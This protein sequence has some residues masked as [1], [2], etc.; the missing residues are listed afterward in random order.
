V[1]AAKADMIRPEPRSHTEDVTQTVAP[2]Y[3]YGL[4]PVS[5]TRT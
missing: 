1:T 2:E 4:H 5:L 3:Q